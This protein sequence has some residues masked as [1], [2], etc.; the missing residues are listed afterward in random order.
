MKKFFGLLCIGFVLFGCSP[1]K[2][3]PQGEE[4]VTAS[5]PQISAESIVT[6]GEGQR[7][8]G[9]ERIKCA[10]KLSCIKDIAKLENYGTCQSTVVDET[11]E[12]SEEQTPVC[13]LRDSNKNAYLNECEA[14]RHGVGGSFSA[15]GILG[16]DWSL[17]LWTVKN[18][19]E[20]V[21][22]FKKRNNRVEF[23]AP[24]LCGMVCIDHEER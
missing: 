2:G 3:T 10:P 14:E 1:H 18:E 19:S 4:N 11:M 13:G 7:C 6:Q 15:G 5:E 22:C 8:G 23:L 21:F 20:N 12:C 24:V 17:L 9:T 16:V